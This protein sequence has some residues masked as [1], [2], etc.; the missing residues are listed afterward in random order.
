MTVNN[1]QTKKPRNYLLLRVRSFVVH[2]TTS[3]LNTYAN[4]QKKKEIY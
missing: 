1:Q 2:S 4:L 3:R